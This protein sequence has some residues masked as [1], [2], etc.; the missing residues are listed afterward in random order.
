MKTMQTLATSWFKKYRVENHLLCAHL[1]SF[2]CCA[3]ST[4]NSLYKSKYNTFTLYM[5]K[6]NTLKLFTWVNMIH[7]WNLIQFFLTWVN[8]IHVGAFIFLPVLLLYLQHVALGLLSGAHLH[9]L[10]KTPLGRGLGVRRRRLLQRLRSRTAAIWGT[11]WNTDIRDPSHHTSSSDTEIKVQFVI[12]RLRLWQTRGHGNG[13]QWCT[14][15]SANDV[16]ITESQL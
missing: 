14:V 7:E 5:S 3:L 10:Q 6:S 11:K 2:I 12:W 8:L 15:S 4:S 9:L 1:F 16:M 13:Q